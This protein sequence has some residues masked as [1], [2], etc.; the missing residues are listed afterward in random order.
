MPLSPHDILKF[1][2]DADDTYDFELLNLLI[3]RLNVLCFE[4]CEIDRISCTLSP[5][6]T[7]RFLLKLRIKAGL[8]TEDLPKFCYSVHKN[9]VLRDFRNKTVVYRPFDSFL[10]LVD[11]LDISKIN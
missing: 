1:F 4:E 11:F 9:V 2:E 6:C 10:Y 3:K 5:K 8:A 7:R